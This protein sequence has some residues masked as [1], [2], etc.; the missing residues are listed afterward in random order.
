MKLFY[1]HK[2]DGGK[3][4]IKLQHRKLWKNETNRFN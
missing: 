2:V 1:S 4:N 3:D